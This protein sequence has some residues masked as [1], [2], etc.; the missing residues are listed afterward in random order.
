MSKHIGI[1]GCSI[2]GTALCYR[3]ICL[4]AAWQMGTFRHPE[5]S[6]H[7]LPLADYMACIR[8]DDWPGVAD[9]LLCSAR[10]LA[11]IGAELLIC[12]DNTIHQAFPWVLGASPLPWLH[13]AE[14][15]LGEARSKGFQRVG[16]LG[17]KYLVGGPVYA[18]K[19]L[20]QKI[21]IEIPEPAHC[22]EID[23]IIFEELNQDLLREQSRRYLHEVVSILGGHGCE[24]VILGCTELPL[25]VQ[26]EKCPLPVLDSTRLLARAVIQASLDS[27]FKLNL[28][29]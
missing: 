14:V 25:L 3:T 4:E 22:E 6:L 1:V 13:I 17:T 24:A 21:G 10:K 29:N 7:N 16:L 9:L 20:L 2:D 19:A 23:R 12:P 28:L 27:S 5:V 11:Q 8:R 26:P 18:E 15:V